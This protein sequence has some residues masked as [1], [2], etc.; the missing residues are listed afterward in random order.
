MAIEFKHRVLDNGLT[1]IAEVDANAHSAAAGYF[2]RTGARDEPAALMGVSHF[3]EHMMFKGTASISAEELN[4]RFD[5]LG[6]RHNAYTSSE[7]T[8]FYA[9]V[10]PDVM[11]DAVGL[12]SEMMRPALRQEDFDTEKQVI[13]EEIAMYADNP[14]WV[15]YEEAM[16]RYYAPHAM[17]HRVLGTTRSITDLSRDAMEGYFRDRYAPDNMVLSIAGRVEFDRVCALAESA[18]GDW[19][20]TGARRDVGE[21]GANTER[22][23]LKDENVSRGYLLGVAPAPAQDDE[24]R[25]AAMVLAKLLGGGGNSRLHW[26]L[27]EEGI[28]EEALAEY[29]PHDGCGTYL[30]YASG[31]PGS[32]TTF[33]EVI[34][35]EIAGLVESVTPTD[36]E[37]IRTRIRTGE[38]TAGERPEGRMQRLGRR[39]SAVG[40]YLPLEEK[41]AR[42][43]AVTEDKIAAVAAAFD[44]TPRLIGTLAPA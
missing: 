14:F 17:G 36:L 41:L 9:H 2:V 15:L 6:A 13:L 20:P 8:C 44:P 32:L 23:S 12:L 5:D 4:E 19:E 37:R 25:Y 26:A 7:V 40:D 42:I 30:V 34:N 27:V 24:A 33:A 21:P 39:W 16:A 31:E 28:A 43:N 18:C 11:D 35:R 1:V 22:F 10:L 38:T 3:L 29:S